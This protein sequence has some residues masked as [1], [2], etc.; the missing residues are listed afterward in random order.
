MSRGKSVA[1]PGCVLRT[2]V[3]IIQSSGIFTGRK[4]SSR[5]P[6][7]CPRDISQNLMFSTD[8][9][10]FPIPSIHITGALLEILV[11]RPVA[12]NQRPWKGGPVVKGVHK[13]QY[14]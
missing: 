13:P 7:G 1:I 2:P 3:L 14:L 4:A 5:R 9:G 11:P 8:G 6:Y 10:G 12:L